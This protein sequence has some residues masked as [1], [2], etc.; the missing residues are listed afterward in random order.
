[1]AISRSVSDRGPSP[2]RDFRL[3]FARAI[4]LDIE[5]TTTPIAFVKDVLFP[6]ARRNA[7]SFLA[8][9]GHEPEVKADLALLAEER[10][11]ERADN[12]PSGEAS[13]PLPYSSG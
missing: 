11:L 6:F 1:M 8:A 3:T 12:A 5:G 7:A 9:H 2:P 13:D 10:A 4:L